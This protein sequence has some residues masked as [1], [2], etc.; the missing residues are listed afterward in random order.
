MILGVCHRISQAKNGEP[1]NNSLISIEATRRNVPELG[2]VK[3][4]GLPFDAGQQDSPAFD[5]L[6]A[7]E[8]ALAVEHAVLEFNF[9]KHYNIT[10]DAEWATLLPPHK[11][12]VKLG[13]PPEEFD[14]GLFGYLA[15]LEPI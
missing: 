7:S 1:R 3:F 9:G 14:V 10:D 2:T 5:A 13:I 15:C 12:R 6:I 11:G 4:D 8:K